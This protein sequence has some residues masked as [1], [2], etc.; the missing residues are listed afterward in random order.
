MTAKISLHVEAESTLDLHS[1]LEA[2]LNGTSPV[3]AVPVAAEV[4]AGPAS[5][6]LPLPQRARKKREKDAPPLAAAPVAAQPPVSTPAP[7]AAPTPAAAP[8]SPAPAVASAPA[9]GASTP[10]APVP[11]IDEVRA[12][13][14][15]VADHEKLGYGKATELLTKLGVD[16]VS[17]VPEDK[18]AAFIDE[19]KKLATETPK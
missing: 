7:V 2:I 19:C 12:A 6:D 9:A 10:A 1:T 5:V 8:P 16:R 3:P 11:S 15:L 17:V 13:L 14:K 18:R 4:P